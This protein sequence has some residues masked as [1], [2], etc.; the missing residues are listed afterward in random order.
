MCVSSG[1]Q[2]ASWQEDRKGQDMED[3]HNTYG[4]PE[5]TAYYGGQNF[6]KQFLMRLWNQKLFFFLYKAVI[7]GVMFILVEIVY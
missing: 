2:Y 1:F 3:F 5:T 4:F 6:L 7:L